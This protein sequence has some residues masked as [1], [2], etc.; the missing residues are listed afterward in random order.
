MFKSFALAILAAIAY[1]QNAGT[2][3]TVTANADGA[4]NTVDITLDDGSSETITDL[5]ID[6]A[7]AAGDSISFNPA[8]NELSINGVVVDYTPP[9]DEGPGDEENTTSGDGADSGSGSG[10]GADSGSVGDG[11]TGEAESNDNQWASGPITTDDGISIEIATDWQT[12]GGVDDQTEYQFG[13]QLDISAIGGFATGQRIEM[14][15]GT[16]S[17]D[18][19]SVYQQFNLY[20]PTVFQ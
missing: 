6:I 13:L 3:D 14:A 1:A 20:T 8:T 17:D 12:T 5:P 4:T 19:E 18:P 10:D 11:S 2:V 7:V 15:W 16:A 9:Q